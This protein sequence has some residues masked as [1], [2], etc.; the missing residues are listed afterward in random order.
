MESGGSGIQG[1][2][3]LH[4]GSVSGL[5]NKRPVSK[6]KGGG[7]RKKG[8]KVGREGKKKGEMAGARI[9]T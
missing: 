9:R 3:Q 7:G 6:K 2:P 8:R 4:S 5:G 1:H